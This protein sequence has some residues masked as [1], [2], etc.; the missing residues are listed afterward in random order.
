MSN[1]KS[2]I[3]TKEELLEILDEES[4]NWCDLEQLSCEAHPPNDSCFYT[5]SVRNVESQKLYMFHAELMPQDRIVLD[6]LGFPV[7]DFNI[8]L[9]EYF[10]ATQES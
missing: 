6:S 10:P 1:S 3:I 9:F 2:L 8:D 5:F 4:D 7:M